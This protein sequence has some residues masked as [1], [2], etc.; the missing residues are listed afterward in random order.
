MKCMEQG[1]LGLKDEQQVSYDDAQAIVIPFGL[2]ASVSYGGGTHQGP[3]AIIQASHEV[4]LF[5]ET[6]WCE[7]YHHIGVSTLEPP[8]IN[9]HTMHD[10]L[11]TLEQTVLS[12]LNDQKFPL[13]LGGEH[14]L[15]A[16]AIRPF[17]RKFD[18]IVLLHFDAHADLRDGYLGE[19]YSHASAI[20][21]CLDYQNISVVS[22]GI[23]N[24]SAEEIPFLED[25]T[26]RMT[27]FW[28]KDKKNFDPEDLTK[29]LK[30]KHVY[31][32]FD[33]DGF[34]ASLMPATGTPEP[35]GL[36]WQDVMD[37]LDIASRVATFVGADI[38]ELAPIEHMHAPNFIAAK[39]AYKILSYAFRHNLPTR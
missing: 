18:E 14:S 2:E 16:G 22:L 15:T 32:T 38:T 30:N 24:I 27:I 3:D 31:V 28:A 20:R 25:N 37:V 4:E 8:P 10:A 5:D 11:S 9:P 19:H 35:G 29:L 6:F 23:R 7:P 21:R 1:F 17:T 26:H 34:D 36:F 39:L 12:V 13:I 33:V